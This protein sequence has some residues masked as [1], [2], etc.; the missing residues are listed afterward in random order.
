MPVNVSPDPSDGAQEA[1]AKLS[2]GGRSLRRIRRLGRPFALPVDR[3]LIRFNLWRLHWIY[4]REGMEGIQA[5]LRRMRADQ[6]RVLRAFGATVAGDASLAGPISVVNSERDFSNLKIGP[7]THI[8]SEVFFDLAGR[9]TI[10]EGA[11]VSM[12]AM[13]ISHLDVG[14]G[15]LAARRPRRVAPVTIGRGAFVGAGAT[16]LDG[17]TVGEEAVIGAGVVVTSDVP[18]GSVVRRPA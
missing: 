8:G 15:P 9:I 1:D 7:L 6:A 11:T 3:L 13:I 5:E 17:V 16:I 18:D 12:R 2:P 14:R 10:E 4:L